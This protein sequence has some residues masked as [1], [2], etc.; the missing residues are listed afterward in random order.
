[1]IASEL[2]TIILGAWGCEAFKQFKSFKQ[3]KLFILSQSFCDTFG[4]TINLLALVCK[5]IVFGEKVYNI[6]ILY[7]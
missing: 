2:K 1:M 7:I 4:R 3:F 6:F 5:L